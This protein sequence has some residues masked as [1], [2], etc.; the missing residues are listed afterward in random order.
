MM[1][2]S[3]CYSCGEPGH[4]MKDCTNRRGQEKGKDKVQLN[5][6]SD[7]APRSN[8]SPHSILG[9]KVRHLW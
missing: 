6:S 7:E 1:G 4:M 3:A 9:C 8:N 5:G 2:A